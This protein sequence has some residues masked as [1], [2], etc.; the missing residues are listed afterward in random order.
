MKK[1]IIILLASITLFYCKPIEDKPQQVTTIKQPKEPVIEKPYSNPSL[2]YSNSA[3]V[4]FQTLYRN[5]FFDLMMSFTS[6]RTIKQFGKSKILNYYKHNFK[7]DYA[8]GKLSNIY[9]EGDTINLS[10]T[11][12]CIY[13]TRRKVVIPFCLENDSIKIILYS[14][15]RNPLE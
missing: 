2:I 3:G 12:A 1:S 13:G 11:H 14:L 7:F 9:Y 5:N 15:T 4:F 6:D 8:I 10:Y